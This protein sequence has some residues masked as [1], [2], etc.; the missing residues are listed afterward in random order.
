MARFEEHIDRLIAK[1]GGFVLTD[2]RTDRG[3]RTYAGISE[4]GN[5]DWEG[6]KLLDN[7]PEFW[8]VRLR[9]LVHLRYRQRY[10]NPIRGDEIESDEIADAL[11]SSAVVS[12]PR[13]AVTIAQYAL[14]VA[15]DGKMGPITLA[16]VNA[17]DPEV[18]APM[19]ALARIARFSRIVNADSETYRV[20]DDEGVQV[21]TVKSQELNF[22]GWANRVLRER[23]F[24][25]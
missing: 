18:F 21:A 1:E 24:R 23:G 10:W 25:V 11:F 22:W 15:V 6:W 2:R 17:A 13:R 8:N 16:H 19:F 4:R 5:P 7:K 9:R 3:G 12:G 20:V 14:G